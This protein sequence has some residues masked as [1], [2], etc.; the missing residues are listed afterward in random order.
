MRAM[1]ERVAGSELR[2]RI[3]RAR[4]VRTELP[5][6]FTL[7]ARRRPKPAGERRGGRARDEDG[8]TLVVDWKSDPLEEREPEELP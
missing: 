3:A 7:A 5:F 6:A 1:V 4:R 8:G 2:E